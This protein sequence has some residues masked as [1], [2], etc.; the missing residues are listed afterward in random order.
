MIFG[1]IN[2]AEKYF[3]V[4]RYFAEAFGLLKGLDG[5]EH[6]RITVKDGTFWINFAEFDEI[7]TGDKPF[8]AHKDFLDIHYIIE[9]EEKFG[10][11]NTESLTESRPYDKENDYLLLSGSADIL[12]LKKGDFCIVFP[13]DAH[14]PCMSKGN[15]KLKKA[16]VKIKLD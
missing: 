16:I 1:N 13:E 12:T 6:E 9:G 3:P 8:E 5:S 2:D 10:C 15:E 7:A 4:N 11:A 14:I